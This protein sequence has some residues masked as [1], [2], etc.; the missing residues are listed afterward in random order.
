MLKQTLVSSTKSRKTYLRVGLLGGG[1]VAVGP[2]VLLG[3]GLEL[4]EVLVLGGEVV[5]IV[6]DESTS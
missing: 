3:G 6:V 2:T 5:G 1:G 4:V